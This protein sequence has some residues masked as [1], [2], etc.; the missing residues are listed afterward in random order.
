MIR[1]VKCILYKGIQKVQHLSEN[2]IGYK[3]ILCC[4]AVLYTHSAIDV[5]ASYYQQGNKKCVKSTRGVK[6]ALCRL[7]GRDYHS[8]FQIFFILKTLISVIK[9]LPE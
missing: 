2:Q 3:G 8:R 7:T 4:Y 6:I 5:I 1:A 9:T